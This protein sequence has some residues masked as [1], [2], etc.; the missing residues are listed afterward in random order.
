MNRS[1]PI[2][3]EGLIK[4]RTVES[5][6]IEYKKG[7]NPD[8]IIKSVCAI[9][10]RYRNGCIGEYF[11]ELKLSEGRSTGFPT[12]HKVALDNNS[13]QVEFEVDEDRSYVVVTVR[14]HKSFEPAIKQAIKPAIKQEEISENMDEKIISFL[15]GKGEQKSSEIVNALGYS[16][17]SSWVRE[18]LARLV[19]DKRIEAT[20]KNKGR[21]YKVKDDE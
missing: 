3:I 21:K 20:G 9:T 10:R 16:E 19:K 11:K 4:A 15:N 17:D 7:W 8:S 1:L 2:N 5:D 6:R 14:I 12:I 18:V 13:P